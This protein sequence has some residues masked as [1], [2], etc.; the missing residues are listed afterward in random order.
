MLNYHHPLRDYSEFVVGL[1][2]DLPGST[3]RREGAG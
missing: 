1:A 3:G 2:D